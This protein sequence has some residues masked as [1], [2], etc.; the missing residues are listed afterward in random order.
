MVSKNLKFGDICVKGFFS[1]SNVEKQH[2]LLKERKKNPKTIM[3]KIKQAINGSE[4][5]EEF[6]S[7]DSESEIEVDESEWYEDLW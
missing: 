7:I 4:Q 1:G 3:Q 6:D 2:K 5:T